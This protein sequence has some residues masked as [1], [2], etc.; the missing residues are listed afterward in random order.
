MTSS[1]LSERLGANRR[2]SD[3][4]NRWLRVVIAVLATIGAI[5]TGSITLKRW[6]LLGSLSCPGGADGCDKVLGSAW[7]TLLGQ[8]L[9]L[10]GFLAYAAVLLMALLPLVLRGEARARLASFSW[11][12]LVLFSTGMAVFSLVLMGVMVLK[13]QAF[14]FFCVLSATLSLALFVLALIGGEWSDRG[15]L[16]FRVVLVGLVV[17]LVGL[18]W[19]AA[20]DRPAAGGGR[21]VPLAVTTTSTPAT[22]ALA[23]HLSASGAVMYTAWWCPHCHDQKQLFGREAV[24]RLKI[25]ECAPDGRN[26][27]KE[28][29]AAKRIEGFPTWEINGRLD[30]GV[31]PLQELARLSGYAGLQPPR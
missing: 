11:W 20:V 27:Q 18:G 25:V 30:S 14:C 7:G 12:G 17:A 2:R 31:K 13:I 26:S 8:P 16:V 1:R 9:S 4:G 10:Y 29:C 5:D 22:I 21:G 15:Q 24:A 6:G 23:E 3:T 19:A 28:L